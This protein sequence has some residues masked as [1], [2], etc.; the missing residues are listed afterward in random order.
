[1]SNTPK[2]AWN[3]TRAAHLPPMEEI[4]QFGADGEESVYRLL[5]NQFDVVIRNVVV[6]HKKLYLEK[7]FMVICQNV[8]FILEVK[9]WKGEI[10]CDGD[11]FYQLKENGIRKTL[12]NPVGTTK[13]FI[14][15]MRKFYDIDRPVFGMV[16]F[17]EPDCTLSLPEEMDGIALLSVQTAVQAIKRCAAAQ[18][19]K[20]PALDPSRILRC[21]RFYSRDSEFCKGILADCFLDC[22]TADGAIVR[23]DTTCLQ[24]LSVESQPLLLRDKLHVTYING[25]T[26]TFYNRDTELTVGCLDGSYRKIAL[27]RIRHIVF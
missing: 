5:C 16:L 21:T 14:E 13:Q 18:K 15:V 27:H 26:D 8:L 11:K 12:K 10:G 22:A 1:M 23:L 20:E 9:N 17:A 4:E 25:A 2:I 19:A 24:Y 3:R 6:P 7:D